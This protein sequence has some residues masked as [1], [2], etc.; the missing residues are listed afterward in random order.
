MDPQV[1]PADAHE[2]REHESHEQKIGFQHSL[3]HEADVAVY[4][5]KLRGRNC[6]VSVSEIPHLDTFS[7]ADADARLAMPYVPRFVPRPEPA[8]DVVRSQGG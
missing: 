3:L 8:G 2:E 4:H 1:N 7:S 5:A 6:V